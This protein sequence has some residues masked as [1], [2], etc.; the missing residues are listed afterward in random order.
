MNL[1]ELVARFGLAPEPWVEGRTI[2][3][4]DPGFSQRM[5][6]EHLSQQHDGASRPRSSSTST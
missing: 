2:P 1:S 5:L 6:R 4:D 3:W